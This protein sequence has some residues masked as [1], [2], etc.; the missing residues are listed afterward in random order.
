MRAQDA[1]T[2]VTIAALG[3]VACWVAWQTED[4]QNGKP[5]KVPYSPTGARA[6]ADAP[7]SWGTRASAETMAAKLPKPYGLGGVG[8]EL[9][10]LADGSAIGG[11][12]LD[13]CRDPVS[14][15]IDQWATAIIN[16]FASYTEISPSG[17]GVKIFFTYST[18]DLPILRK[19]MDGSAYG[20][21]FKRGGGDHPPAI[22]LHLGNRYFAVTDQGLPD[23]RGEFRHIETATLLELIQTTGP[24]FAADPAGD[25]PKPGR[26][27]NDRSRSSR[28]FRKG[29]DLRRTGATFDEMVAALRADDDPDIATWTLEKGE[30]NG[31]RELRRVWDK[32]AAKGPVIRVTAGELHTVTTAAEDALLASGLPIYQRGDSLVQPIV[33]DV[34]AARG[35]MTRAAGLGDMNVFSMVDVLCAT[36]EY[37]KF[38]GRTESWVRTNPPNQVAQILLSRQGR[39]RLPSIRGVITTPTLRPDGTLLAEA[40]YDAATRLYHTA[41]PTL[42]LRQSVFHPT[43]AAAEGA[44]RVLTSLLSGFPFVTR[45]DS[46]EV[47]KAVALS[48]LITPVVRGALPVTP[49]HVIN[50]HAPGSGKSYFVDVASTIAT[51]RPCPVISAAPDESETEK[52]IVGLLLAGFPVV[53]LDNC[54][55]EIGGDLLCQAIERPLI[56]L[57]RLG[58]SDITEIEN[59]VTMFSTGNNARVR[60]DMVRRSLIGELDPQ[61]ER[62]ELR[63]FKSDPVATI[64]AD[65]GTYVSA[66]LVIVRAYIADGMPDK[67]TPV[68]S[69]DDWSDKVRSALVWLGCA[70][71]ALSMEA[72]RE[73]DPELGELTEMMNA[74]H[75]AFGNTPTTSRTAIETAQRKVAKADENGDFPQY[76]P[77]TELCFPDLHAAISAVASVRGTAL[78]ATKLGSWLRAREGR[79]V[80]KQRFKRDGTTQ[81]SA[82]WKLEAATG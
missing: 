66:C 31:Q 21:Q 81:G 6:R 19:A 27:T 24:E 26:A 78:D 53:S 5:T 68:A 1:P 34:P 65:R 37:E 16:H 80:G 23:C 43:R 55:G 74:W 44:L 72:A 17:T 45:L 22:E 59:A 69:F 54:N 73:D 41:D 61:V 63:T 30:A 76:A 71:P 64:Q 51:G 10:D 9:G 79:I 29:G 40:G 15:R 36:A 12:D 28:A 52:R 38:D 32:A 18:A 11:I 47:S 3:P 8:I 49:L 13:T 57:R 70:D 25:G 39:W 67:L 58:G 60:G 4:R 7:S 2:A 75:G 14:G 77:A 62:P 35:R 56:R 50:A 46:Q 42:T 48:G 82:R 20:K 33:R